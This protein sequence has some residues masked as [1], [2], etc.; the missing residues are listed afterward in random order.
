[1]QGRVVVEDGAALGE[2]ELQQFET[3]L[4][5]ITANT[6]TMEDQPNSRQ[7]SVDDVANAER[8]IDNLWSDGLSMPNDSFGIESEQIRFRTA[9][10]GTSVRSRA[11]EED[12]SESMDLAAESAPTELRTDS[13]ASLPETAKSG[14]ENLTKRIQA[15]LGGE[16]K[17]PAVAKPKTKQPKTWRRVKAAPNTSR[18]M[19]GDHDELDMNGMQVHVQVDGFRARVLVDCFY[20]NDRE[21]QLEGKFKLRLPDD[22]S[23]YY[24]AFGQSAFDLTGDGELTRNEFIE[25]NTTTR[26]VA[27][28]PNNIKRQRGDVWRNV[29]ESRMVPREKAAYAYSQTVRRRVDPALVE[30]SGAGVFNA[31]VFPLMPKKLHRI[32]I[33]YDVDLQQTDEGLVYN[34][35]LPQSIRQCKVDIDVREIDGATLALATD[36]KYTES[37]SAGIRSYRIDEPRT[38]ESGAIRLT[39]AGAENTVLLSRNEQEG[40]FFATRVKLDLPDDATTSSERA[41]FMVDTSL[42]SRPDKFNVWLNLLKATLDNN[43]DSLKEFAV[44][45]F[46]VETRFWRS[47]YSANTEENV[48]A[49]LADC[50]KIT[51]EGATD[52]FSATRALTNTDWVIGS[53]SPDLFLLSDGASNWGENNLRLIQRELNNEQLGSVFAYQTGMTGT[54][55]SGLRFLASETG[56]AVFSV[57]NEDEVAKASTAHRARP[58][59]LKA[60][61]SGGTSDILTAGRVQWV[62]PGQLITVVGRLA[63]QNDM[64]DLNFV[65]QQGDTKQTITVAPHDLIESELASRLYGHVAVGQLESLDQAELDVTTAYARHF[66]I[67]GD[68]CSL[69]MLESEADYERFNIKPE[70]DLFVVKT[71]TAEELISKTLAEKSEELGDPKTQLLNWVARLES[72]PGMNFKVP[73]ALRLAL[74]KIEVE[75]ITDNLHED[76]V[77]EITEKYLEQLDAQRL[78]Y[79]AVVQE[80]E[81][82]GESSSAL[83]IK[84]LSSLIEQNPGDLVLA[85]DVAF[86]AMEMSRPSQAYH[87]LRRIAMALPYDPSIYTAIG[88][89]LTQMD[90]ADMA[91][92]F[93]EVALGGNFQNRSNDFRK[94]AGTEY[95]FLLR[96]IVSDQRESKI[97]S[98]AQ[99]RLETIGQ[100]YK[101]ENS[102]DMLITMMWNTDQTDVDLHVVEPS[103]EECFYS[104]PRT[105]SGGHITR[106]IT[107]GYGPEMYAINKA[108]AGEY[109][110]MVKYFNTNPNRAGMRS[111]VY[112]TIY[113][114]FGTGSESVTRQVVKITKPGQ[115]ERVE[116]LTLK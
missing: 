71:T 63:D 24:F 97:K 50:E 106:D 43:R 81:R 69:L 89:C 13:L 76:E 5:L 99:A 101:I 49:L 7:L 70:E 108:P 86:T 18:L 107:D 23:L 55:I 73:T 90:Q 79:D 57:A 38:E 45:F 116:T 48:A 10:G 36:A 103:G 25:P 37:K 91:I 80:A 112:L 41:V 17:R 12:L 98:Y 88:Q 27:L 8:K 22:A 11:A 72:M 16:A 82:R 29:K 6:Q 19:V 35:D 15:D 44:L 2:T 39:M 46:D 42:S 105:R 65:L 66:R 58:W 53:S 59:Q 21:Q 110:I 61:E 33:G 31:N 9:T 87:L 14:V 3:N 20:Y 83:A 28:K 84:V 60:I 111:K 109:N 67:T 96:Q 113:R 78:N 34:L 40:D 85:R 56:G 1:M 54:A 115:K 74:D 52:L 104:H 95:A 4:S 26:L 47:S 30:W 94:I 32:V 114:D 102:A 51:L 100:K 68:T 93:Y 62:Y 77:V 92:V 75:A 64:A